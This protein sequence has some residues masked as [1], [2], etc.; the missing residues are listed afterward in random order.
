M[1]KGF[2][3]LSWWEAVPLLQLDYIIQDLRLA[4]DGATGSSR[5]QIVD[6]LTYYEMQKAEYLRSIGRQEDEVRSM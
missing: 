1:E 5:Q 2:E 4:A 3:S 6:N